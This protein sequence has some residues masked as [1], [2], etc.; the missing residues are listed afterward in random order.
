[1]QSWRLLLQTPLV[2]HCTGSHMLAVQ[3]GLPQLQLAV[4]CPGGK[5]V[6][7]RMLCQADRA[8]FRHL[9]MRTHAHEGCRE[10]KAMDAFMCT[11]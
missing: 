1:M 3:S 6:A 7:M 11:R 8:L 2:L 9:C 5:Q 10:R 4:V